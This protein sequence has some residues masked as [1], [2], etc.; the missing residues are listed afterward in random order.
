MSA[1]EEWKR[2]YLLFRVHAWDGDPWNMCSPRLR[3]D[4]HKFL[5][6]N[7]WGNLEE[8]RFW[9]IHIDRKE[10]IMRTWHNGKPPR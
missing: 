6:Q 9:P 10:W 7:P 8:R 1:R 5:R 2:F 3:D 4:M